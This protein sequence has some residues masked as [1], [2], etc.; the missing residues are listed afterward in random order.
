MKNTLG[1]A[2]FFI[3]KD[4]EIIINVFN[5][6]EQSVDPKIL[7]LS[8]EFNEFKNFNEFQ[9]IIYD[10]LLILRYNNKTNKW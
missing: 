3:E 6:I 1:K 7:E 8:K 10:F 5:V 2:L 9:F 4:N